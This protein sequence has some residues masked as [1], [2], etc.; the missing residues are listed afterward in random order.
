MGSVFLALVP[1]ADGGR[2]LL[3]LK[4][5]Q[6]ELARDR[7]FRAMFEAEARLASRLHHPNVVETSDIYADRDLCVIVMEFLDG[8]TL[9][10]IRQR[11]GQGATVPFAIHL[12]VLAGA[13]AGLHYVH[14]LTDEKGTPL[15]IVHRDIS[16]SNVFVTYDGLTKVVDFGIAKATLHHAETR[17]GVL[18]GKLAYMSPEAVRN[19]RL[20]R[21]SDIFSVGVMLWEAAT[22]SRF[23]RGHDEV[24]VFQ[25]LLA[26]DLPIQSPDGL[27]RTSGA[28]LRI[29]Q[30]ALSVDPSQRYA[31]AE[32]MR[33]ELEPVLAGLG[34]V[35]DRATLEAYMDAN[36][37]ADRQ[38]VRA[39]VGD[40]V[41]RIPS[42]PGP[43]RWLD[44]TAPSRAAD[45]S[46][47]PTRMAS[48]SSG[49]GTLRTVI[50]SPDVFGG[51]GKP[52][53]VRRGLRRALGIA[54]GAAAAAIGV[55]YVSHGPVVSQASA[56]AIPSAS[57]STVDGPSSVAKEQV[58]EM[59][60]APEARPT[61]PTSPAAPATST[62]RSNEI[63]VVFVARPAHA[64]L[65]LDGIPLS[66][67]PVRLQM[68][69]DDKR[70][71]LRV[72]AGGYA[73][74]LRTIELNRDVA[75]EFELTPEAPHGVG[76]AP[77]AP[78]S[79]RDDPWG[80]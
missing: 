12:R 3:V 23:W 77:K 43:Q 7:E 51:S 68:L 54:I 56:I 42:S 70:H 62:A 50:S 6:P 28:M 14:E 74:L 79:T 63:L 71:A 25:H 52:Q 32:E 53:N 46:E 35:A 15:G 59:R 8:Q 9:A 11:G 58:P 29:A 78:P 19:E 13:L 67:N 26:G 45:P 49:D 37:S 66:E 39:A 69:P 1:N 18:K 41:G 22:G 33:L 5:L 2:R 4:Q 44:L 36:F 80:I 57:T 73:P 17:V 38:K 31:T 24:S 55:A 40:A 61:P 30:R 10:L 48:P 21:R 47:A 65:F 27:G 16:P 20:D 76:A 72:E 34:K 60:E 75:K 64:R